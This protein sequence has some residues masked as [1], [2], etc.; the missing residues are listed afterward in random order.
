MNGKKFQIFE[1][2]LTCT[3]L[4]IIE[5]PAEPVVPEV[6]EVVTEVVET[7]SVTGT[8]GKLNINAASGKEINER[9]G[10]H[11]TTAYA[12]VGYR[13]KNGPYEKLEDLLKVTNVYPGTLEKFRDTVWFGPGIEE[14]QIKYTPRQP[15]EPSEQYTGEKVNINTAK[16]EEIHEKIG[17]NKSVCYYITGYRKK[18]GPYKSIDEL[19]N[20][21]R[22]TEYHLKYYGPRLEV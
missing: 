6:A 11:I 18:N 3:P 12:V 16:A 2:K 7:E 8:E 10:L 17:L 15:K 14:T 5:I 21:P 20:V 22:F 19:L 9:T 13:R 4:E 1:P